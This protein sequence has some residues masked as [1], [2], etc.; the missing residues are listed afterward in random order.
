MKIFRTFT[1]AEADE[2]IPEVSKQIENLKDLQKKVDWLEV[3]I[4]LD[5]MMG[6]KENEK[7][8]KIQSWKD[9]REGLFRLIQQ[10]IEEIEEMGCLL[11]DIHHGVVDFCSVCQNQIVYLSWQYGE[12]EVQ[13]MYFSNEVYENRRPIVESEKR[14][15]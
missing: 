9:Q 3:Q 10:G 2:L 11:K 4:D 14:K 6:L 12:K 7:I 13:Y 1:K 15:D 5:L 8:A